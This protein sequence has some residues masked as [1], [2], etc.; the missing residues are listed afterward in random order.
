MLQ[1]LKNLGKHSIIYGT[2]LVISKAVGFFLIPLYTHY[3]RPSDYGT[4]ELLDL[5]GFFI[6]FFIMLGLNQGVLRSF[7]SYDDIRDKNSVV[8]T[9]ILFVFSLGALIVLV[10]IPFN[11]YISK[12]ILS[13]SDYSSLFVLLLISIFLGA[14]FDIE[15][16]VLR[17]HEKSLLYSILSLAFTLISILLNI[18][19]IAVLEIGLKGIYYSSIITTGIIGIYLSIVLIRETGIHFD[20]KKLKE[21]LAFSIPFVPAGIFSFILMWS[22]RYILRIFHDLETIGYYA[23]GFKLA[24]ILSFVIAT[25][26]S[27]VWGSYIFEINKM[28]NARNIYATIATYFLLLMCCVGLL[29]SVF[30]YELVYIM[31]DEHYI[32]AYTVIPLLVLGVA[33]NTSDVVMR[34]GL[35][36][37]GKSF[38]IP[39]CKAIAASVNVVA[40]I[41]LIPKYGM[42]GA[43]LATVISF[44]LSITLL[45]VFSQRTYYIPFEYIR[46]LKLFLTTILIYMTCIF[47]PKDDLIFSIMIKIFILLTFPIILYLIRFYTIDE[48]KGLRKLLVSFRA[49]K[50][51]P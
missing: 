6:T 29:I 40:N 46:L 14:I 49:L 36:V 33:L 41:L 42:M 19:F 15:K 39:I 43:A 48:I 2:G 13:S 11:E 1:H 9:A 34:V 27:L 23:L 7:H 38:Y 45:T 4:M 3:L 18:Y 5:T 25:P 35:L 22:D 10:L 20:I 28:E 50:N 47:V 31:A 17:V 16:T 21:M 26:F 12:I 8:S 37:E 44:A 32:M 24:M 51:N 30:S